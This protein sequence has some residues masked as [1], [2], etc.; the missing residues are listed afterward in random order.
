MKTMQVTRLT[1]THVLAQGLAFRNKEIN[2]E[3]S[4]QHLEEG[5]QTTSRKGRR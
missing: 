4:I 2:K 3:I 5:M 1:D